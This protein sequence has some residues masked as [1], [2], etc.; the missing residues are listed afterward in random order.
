MLGVKLVPETI[1]PKIGLPRGV[2]IGQ[3]DPAGP[4]ARLI[5]G[6]IQTAFGRIQFGDILLA[7]GGEEINST[8]EAEAALAKYRGG[9]TVDLLVLRNGQQLKV[10][11]LLRS[12]PK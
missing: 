3:V 1:N 7:I 8:A 10:P 9:Q 11:I 4:S 12:L 2:I 6:L 5:R